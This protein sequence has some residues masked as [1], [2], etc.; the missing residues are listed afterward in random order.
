MFPV[1]TASKNMGIKFSSK[2]QKKA[3]YY[4]TSST[5]V[6]GFK[7]PFPLQPYRIKARISLFPEQ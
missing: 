3:K 5:L 1:L 6:I 7:K 2:Q 4:K